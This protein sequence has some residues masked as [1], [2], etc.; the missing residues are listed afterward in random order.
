M[1]SEDSED[2]DSDDDADDSDS[3]T[4]PPRKARQLASQLAFF[5]IIVS[6]PARLLHILSSSPSTLLH[7][8]LHLVLDEADRLLSLDD[9]HH[10]TVTSLVSLEDA[11]RPADEGRSF[12][13]QVDK[14]LE[15]CGNKGLRKAC[16]S[17]TVPSG[18][19]EMARSVMD[20]DVVTVRIGGAA[21]DRESS[22]SPLPRIHQK[23]VFCS[24]EAGK[25]MEIR[26]ML[27][28]GD[29]RPPCLI[30]VQSKKRAEEL[31]EELAVDGRSVDVVTGERT[32]KERD[33]LV[34]LFRTGH[35][36]LLICTDLLSRGLDFSAVRTVIN[37]DFPSTTAAYVHRIGRT[38]RAGRE[39]WAFTF[40]THEDAPYVKSVAN[41]MKEM[42][43]KIED[44]MVG[45]DKP[46]R[47]AKKNMKQ[48]GVK[49]ESIDTRPK[50][51]KRRE[52]AKKEMIEASKRRKRMNDGGKV[53][54]GKKEHNNDD[55]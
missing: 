39:G 1:K 47:E 28:R 46:S 48:K 5:D 32:K 11:G 21:V 30:F 43:E 33:N 45:L 29:V 18:V 10:N 13:H 36:H 16:F 53:G 44:W 24:S 6:T 41:V 25:L 27:G 19:E 37:Y 40:F 52:Q 54:Y 15:A 14:V 9:I 7:Q 20:A 31:R 51:E 22:N 2:D 23:L 17:A 26:Q 4:K 8:V 34:R 12:L 38:G 42:G 55:E 3:K 35:L 49:R 50:K